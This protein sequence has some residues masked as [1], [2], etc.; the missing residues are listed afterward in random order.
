MGAGQ[1]LFD[2]S[3]FLVPFMAD[4]IPSKLNSDRAGLC[5]RYERAIP[6]VPF[7]KMP[8]GL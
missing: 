7:E 2:P 6:L 5:S 8:Q 1:G 4:N 3:I